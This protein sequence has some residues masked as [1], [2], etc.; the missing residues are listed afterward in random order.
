MKPYFILLYGS[1]KVVGTFED[2]QVKGYYYYY[3]HHH[4][5]QLYTVN[6]LYYYYYYYYLKLLEI[7]CIILA[8]LLCVSF[9][10]F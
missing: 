9:L 1:E 2:T 3:Y 4:Y 6:Y 10:Y 7:S 5:Y 8:L